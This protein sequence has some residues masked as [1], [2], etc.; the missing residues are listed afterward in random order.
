M[1]EPP[2]LFEPCD[3]ELND[4]ISSNEIPKFKKYPCYTQSVKPSVKLVTESEASACDAEA[5]DGFIRA[6]K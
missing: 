6:I 3:D 2:I 4:Y 1:T 5:R